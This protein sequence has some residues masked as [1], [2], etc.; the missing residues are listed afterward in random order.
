MLDTPHTRF[1]GANGR[2][3]F[4]LPNPVRAEDSNTRDHRPLCHTPI[5][6]FFLEPIGSRDHNAVVF[7]P[8]NNARIDRR[9][10]QVQRAGRF[11]QTA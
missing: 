9:D 6:H 4:I 8:R 2:A 5:L 7:A 1:A 3:E 11:L 10:A